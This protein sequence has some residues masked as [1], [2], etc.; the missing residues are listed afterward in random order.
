MLVDVVLPNNLEG[1]MIATHGLELHVFRIIEE[2][3]APV[4]LLA[5]VDHGELGTAHGNFD[6]GGIVGDAKTCLSGRYTPAF[7]D[8][9]AEHE[10]LS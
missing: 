2:Q 3:R 1:N 7:I 4:I 9:N 8:V 5:E 10:R 6:R